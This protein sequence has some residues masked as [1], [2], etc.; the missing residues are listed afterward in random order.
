MFW[1][2]KLRGTIYLDI[3]ES[4]LIF[5][6]GAETSLT[7]GFWGVFKKSIVSL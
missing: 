2:V 3:M 6:N 4:W 5:I 7:L 1:G